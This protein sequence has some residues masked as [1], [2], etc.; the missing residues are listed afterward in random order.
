M[1]ELTANV[2]W[3]AVIVGAVLAFVAGWLWYSPI[4]FGTKWAAGSKVELGTAANMPMLAM[5]TQGLGLIGVAWV[6][7]ITAATNSLLTIILITVS[8]V[9]L[10]WSGNSFSQKTTY[11]K[12]V[13]ASY[14]VVSVVIMIVVQAVL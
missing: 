8:F 9:L 5:L 11:A 1:E 12:I 4:L 10:Q 2:S 7:A 13:D 14:W 6:V 3:L